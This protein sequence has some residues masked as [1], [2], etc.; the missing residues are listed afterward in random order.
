M[1]TLKPS[2]SMPNNGRLTMSNGNIVE[3]L[4]GSLKMDYPPLPDEDDIT[5][6]SEI[7]A[8]FSNSSFHGI[9]RIYGRKS[10]IICK[11]FWL[12]ITL[13]ACGLFSFQTFTSISHYVEYPTK[14]TVKVYNNILSISIC[15]ESR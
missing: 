14:T 10:P 8:S 2:D 11:F 1:I 5:C 6:S 4:T 15:I 3:S 12:L 13:M 9:P 7:K